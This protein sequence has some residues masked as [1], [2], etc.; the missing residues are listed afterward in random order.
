[1][2][3]RTAAACITR[4]RAHHTSS[5]IQEKTR[6]FFY[7]LTMKSLGAAYRRRSRSVRSWGFRFDSSATGASRSSSLL[8]VALWR[9]W[10]ET[11]WCVVD[12]LRRSFFPPLSLFL[13]IIIYISH[14]PY[15]ES[16]DNSKYVC[17]MNI[18]KYSTF[19]ENQTA[20]KKKSRA[21]GCIVLYTPCT[22]FKRRFFIKFI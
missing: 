11:F 12:F 1:M 15:S 20:A 6:T 14:S 17:R 18:Y 9:Q 7:S 3:T 4:C 16:V 22:S 5:S 10:R 13:S 8:D 21:F 19:I 2:Y